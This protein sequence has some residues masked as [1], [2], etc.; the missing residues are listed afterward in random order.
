LSNAINYGTYYNILLLAGML[1]LFA[2]MLLEVKDDDNLQ[3]YWRKILWLTMLVILWVHVFSPRGIYKYY[4]VLLIP[5]FSIFSTSRMIYSEEEHV[6]LTHYM[7]WVPAVLSFLILIPSRYVYPLFVFFIMI[8]Y[9]FIPRVRRWMKK[10]KG[11][12]PHQSSDYDNDKSK[13]L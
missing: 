11:E 12:E 9:A 4:F 8:G 6:T 2:L 10:P 7:F 1:P 13:W 5:F 3:E